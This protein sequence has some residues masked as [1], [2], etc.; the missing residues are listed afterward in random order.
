MFE[1][2]LRKLLRPQ[3]LRAFSDWGWGVKLLLVPA[4]PVGHSLLSAVGASAAASRGPEG[5]RPNLLSDLRGHRPSALGCYR[6][7]HARRPHGND[8]VP[9]MSGGNSVSFRRWLGLRP[10][11]PNGTPSRRPTSDAGW[12]RAYGRPRCGP[13]PCLAVSPPAGPR[14]AGWTAACCGSAAN[15]PPRRGRSGRARRRSG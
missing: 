6:D 7:R 3:V 13:V 5:G 15:A 10:P 11:C 1:Q 14:R 2:L 8:M 12:W 4:A 9:P